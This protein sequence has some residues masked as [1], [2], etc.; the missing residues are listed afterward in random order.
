MVHVLNMPVD[1][2]D[3][4]EAWLAPPS[5]APDVDQQQQ[6]ISMEISMEG[7]SSANPASPELPANPTVQDFAQASVAAQVTED[8]LQRDPTE[9]AQI[10]PVTDNSMIANADA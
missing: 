4:W 7:P 2:V 1:V 3:A 9:A 5:P 8:E 6:A 10:V